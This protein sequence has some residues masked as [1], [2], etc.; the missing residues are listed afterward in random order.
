MTYYILFCLFL[1]VGCLSFA[2]G[3]R[4]GKRSRKIDLAGLGA[5]EAFAYFAKKEMHR[6]REDIAQ[7]KRDLKLLD[8]AGIHAPD[9][10]LNVWIE[11]KQ[12]NN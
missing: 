6:H 7:I 10:P 4:R 2:Y 3:Y 8:K 12:R 5:Q 1:A 9:I 11:V